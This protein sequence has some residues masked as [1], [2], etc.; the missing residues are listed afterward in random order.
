M[1]P[2]SSS[3]GKTQEKMGAP[4]EKEETGDPTEYSY[5][6][7]GTLKTESRLYSDDP[8]SGHR[9]FWEEMEQCGDRKTLGHSGCRPSSR[10][11]AALPVDSHLKTV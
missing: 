4:G 3:I 1:K 8:S 5:S 7:V 10:L 11:Y 6:Q 9:K 2:C